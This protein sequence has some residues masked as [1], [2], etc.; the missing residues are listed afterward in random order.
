MF[1]KVHPPPQNV[2]RT[3]MDDLE[4]LAH[5]F[6]FT[7]RMLTSFEANLKLQ[8]EHWEIIYEIIRVVFFGYDSRI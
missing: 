3:E 7:Y 5:L 8:L 4:H 1:Q 6:F 2:T